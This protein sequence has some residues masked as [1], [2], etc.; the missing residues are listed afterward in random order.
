MATLKI[1]ILLATLSGILAAVGYRFAGRVGVIIA[2]V[3]STLLN[4]GSYWHSDKIILKMYNAK[5]VSSVDFPGLYATV[6][7]LSIRAQIPTPKVYVVESRTPNAFAAGR[8]KDHAAI[9][10]TSG[11]LPLLNQEELEGVISHELSHIRNKDILVGTM[12][13]TLSGTV[14]LL[15]RASHWLAYYGIIEKTSQTADLIATGVVAP[16]SAT[17]IRLAI[18]R[19]REYGADEAAAKLT[20]KPKALAS[21]LKKI[22]LN[23]RKTHIDANPATAHIFIVNPLAKNIVM[24]LFRTHP[25]TEKRIER[26]EQMVLQ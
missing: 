15:A 11:I 21:A 9:A 17:L 10:V 4:I 19:T 5:P 7:N 25:P 8:D 2:F 22:A 14:V 16:V 13:A 1:I 18:S 6:N 24:N 20:G 12:V 3:F 26:L 23:P